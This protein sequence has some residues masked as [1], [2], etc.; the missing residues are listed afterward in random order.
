[1]TQR[2]AGIRQ[3]GASS[4][5]SRDSHEYVRHSN[6]EYV[7]AMAHT[8]GMKSFWAEMKHGYEGVYHSMSAKHW[9][10][11]VAEFASRQNMRCS[12]TIDQIRF[13]AA[14]MLDA[15][16]LNRELIRR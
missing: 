10:R 11:Y 14:A 9:H 4:Y 3:V 13:M 1:M 6:C 2:T 16:L 5:S 15:C 8:N 12:D 7:R